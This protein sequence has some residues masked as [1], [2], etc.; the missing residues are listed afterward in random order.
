VAKM[1]LVVFV[2]CI[3]L[4]SV[5]G[6]RAEEPKKTDE[7]TAGKAVGEATTEKPAE[8]A[9]KDEEPKV[10]GAG[11]IGFYNRYIFRGYEIGKSGFVMQP[12]LTASYR[13]FSASFWANYDTN[14]Q[15]T[16]SAVFSDP[17]SGA[18]DEVDITLSYTYTINKLSL[19]GGYIYYDVSYAKNTQEF[20]LTAALDVFGK[21][22]ISAYQ[23]VDSYPGTYL[24]L[25]FA[26]SFPIY[27]DITLD[28]GASFG[29]LIGQG[30]YWKTYEPLTGE[31]TGPKFNDFLDGM[32]KVGFTIP[33]T[34]AFSIA[35]S[36]QYWYPLSGD[37]KK[38]YGYNA[39][40][41]L[42]TPYNPN[43]YIKNTWVYGVGFTYSF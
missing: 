31:Y 19:T 10:T 16:T 9:K 34:K 28:L 14:Q 30:S 21:P 23:D 6:L 18:I 13:G 26:Q 27:K 12:S 15:N 33:V 1:R 11:A 40:T 8:E 36:V 42:K 5:I 38:T 25:S 17:G 4:F 20:F 7:A 22:T 2:M 32:V 43:G 24:N 29:Y 35:P 3:M 37:A 39:E 41:G